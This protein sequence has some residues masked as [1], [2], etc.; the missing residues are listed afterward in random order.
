MLVFIVW[1]FEKQQGQTKPLHNTAPIRMIK[2]NI[3]TTLSTT[4]REFQ[5]LP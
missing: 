5:L 4:K 1:K 2:T 3:S